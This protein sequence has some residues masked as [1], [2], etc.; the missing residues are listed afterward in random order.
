MIKLRVAII[1]WVSA[2]SSS[3]SPWDYELECAS[4]ARFKLLFRVLLKVGLVQFSHHK[5][6][7]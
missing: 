3:E 6:L 4:E 7:F 2:A 5:E 1:I